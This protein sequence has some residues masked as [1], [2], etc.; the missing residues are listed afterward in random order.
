MSNIT[1]FEGSNTIPAYLREGDSFTN[2]NA[3]V[4]SGKTI[5]IKGGVWRM[6]VN[7]KEVARNEDRSMKLVVVNMAP[8]ISR[9]YYPGT[10]E[11]G[12]D[13]LPSCFSADGKTPDETAP[14]K[15]SPNCASCPQNVAG[16]GQGKSRACRFN[17]RYAVVLEGDIGGSVYRLQLPAKSLFGEGEGKY[18]PA[19]AYRQFLAGHGVPMSGVVTEAKF[20]TGHAVPV[21]RFRALRSL[22]EQEWAISK[23]QG[24]SAD[25]LQAIEAFKLNGGKA[26]TALPALFDEAPETPALTA[27]AP[28]PVPTAAKAAEPVKRASKKSEPPPPPKTTDEIMNEWGSDDDE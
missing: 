21:L 11:E 19:E 16:S 2:T 15:Q 1:L 14:D 25:A 17:R 12:K 24:Q 5:S 4:S 7:G 26:P 22:T 6:M 28:A 20:D 10:Y 9:M 3:N 23:E 8:S 18:M 27:P 13:T